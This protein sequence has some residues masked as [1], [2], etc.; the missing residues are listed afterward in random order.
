MRKEDLIQTELLEDVE[1]QVLDAMNVTH[2]L[3]EELRANEDDE[4]IIRSVSVIEK[5]L[6]QAVEGFKELREQKAVEE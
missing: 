6:M 5:I 4:H 2:L 1:D 3:I